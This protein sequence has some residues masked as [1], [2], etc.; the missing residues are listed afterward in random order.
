M[1]PNLNF[2]DLK[3]LYKTVQSWYIQV[4]LKETVMEPKWQHAGGDTLMSYLEL[5]TDKDSTI[6]GTVSCSRRRRMWVA[7]VYPKGATPRN[8]FNP[9]FIYGDFLYKE[10]A[11]KA[12]SD[13]L[14]SHLT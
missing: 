12:V 5:K 8:I 2:P 1:S 14:S 3:Y 9:N 13:F 4:S 6:L 7:T 10:D 11:M